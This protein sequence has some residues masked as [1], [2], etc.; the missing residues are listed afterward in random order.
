MAE[1]DHHIAQWVRGHLPYLA[2]ALLLVWVLRLKGAD[3]RHRWFAFLMYFINKNTKNPKI[4]ELKRDFFSSLGSVASHDPVLRKQNGIKILEIGVGTGV[5]FSY[6]PDG[7]HLIVVD[8]NPHFANYYNENRKKYPNIHSEE[9]LSLQVRRRTRL[10]GRG[11]GEAMT[12]VADS[13]VDVVVV[14]LV[15]CSVDNV[16]QI[17]KQVLRVLVPVSPPALGRLLGGKFY[18][19]EHVREFDNNHWVR[20]SLQEWLTISGLWPF[21]FDG[22]CLNRDCLAAIR[23]AGFS[24]VEAVMSYTPLTSIHFQLIKPHLEAIAIK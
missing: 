20:Q 2:L 5:N 14:T 12:G 7:S 3:V 15:L 6:Y 13:S 9:I 22:C 11:P 19:L 18:A 8:P 17:L 24:K 1:V 10:R 16:D 23:S 21:L 4:E